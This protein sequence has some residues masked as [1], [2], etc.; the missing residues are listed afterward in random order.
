MNEFAPG[1]VSEMSPRTLGRWIIRIGEL[2]GEGV[3]HAR[4]AGGSQPR[5]WFFHSLAVGE[6]GATPLNVNWTAYPKLQSSTE[7]DYEATDDSRRL[8]EEYCEWAV[9]REAGAPVEMIFTTE[10]PDYYQF[11]F[12]NDPEL[13]LSLYRQHVGDHVTM[14]DLTGYNGEYDVTNAHNLP[15]SGDSLGTIMHMGGN[16]ANFYIAAII[17]AAQ[18]TWPSEDSSGDPITD[19]QSLIACRGFGVAHRHSDPFIGAQ[20]N[21]QVRLGN[22]VSLGGPPGLYIDS[23][24]FSD[25][26]MPDGSDPIG[27]FTIQRGDDTHIMR[28]SVAV[29]DGAGFQLSDVLV[30][31]QPLQFGS[32]IAEILR[33]RL[34]ALARSDTDAAPSIRCVGAT[35]LGATPTPTGS[36]SHTRFS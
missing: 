13:L 35:P 30:R 16:G 21:Q 8:Q 18:A 7:A 34:V 17:L 9:R 2:L 10:T 22:R 5:A 19:E 29:P 26:T 27:L 31:G 1:R 3:A 12:E 25:I 15:G 20:V 14:E 28:L 32:Q 33:I 6:D 24:N 4:L 36:A 23:V 11:L